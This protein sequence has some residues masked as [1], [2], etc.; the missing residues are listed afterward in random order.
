MKPTATESRWILPFDSP[1]LTLENA[2][3]KGL[4][5][6]RL[7]RLGLP[8]PPGFVVNAACYRSL[9]KGTALEDFI[10]DALSGLDETNRESVAQAAAAIR[11]RIMR[12]G[13][14][15]A[16][17]AE[18]KAAY[19][20]LGG[21]AAAVRSSATAEDLP[22]LSFA[23]QQ[24]T[25]LN[26]TGEENVI[27][28]VLSCLASLWTERAVAYRASHT[29][30]QTDVAIAVVV[31]TLVNAEWSGVMFTANPLSGSRRETVIE[32][33]PGLGESLVSGRTEPDRF[34]LESSTGRVLSQQAG[35]K[36]LVVVPRAAGGVEERRRERMSSSALADGRLSELCA[37]GQ[38]IAAA[39]GGPQDIEWAVR[40]EQIHILQARPVTSLFPVPETP[41]ASPLRAYFSFAGVQGVFDPLTPLGRNIF[42]MLFSAGAR[43]AGFK[44]TYR[45]QPTA[46]T[47]G[48]RLWI[49]ISPLL[50]STLGRRVLVVLRFIEPGVLEALR[51]LKD[52]PA[53][54]PPRPPTPRTFLRL[55]RFVIPIF[56]MMVTNWARAA[57]A[58]P[59]VAARIESLHRLVVS[60]ARRW[61]TLADCVRSLAALD[62]LIY[63][64]MPAVI[65]G[66]ATGM[67]P[68][69]ILLRLSR[70]LSGSEDLGLTVTRGASYNVTTAMDLCL[71]AAARR[72]R[73]N[74]E[75]VEFFK[76]RDAAA[77]AQAWRDGTLPVA[78]R[79]ALDDFFDRYGMRGF[80]EIDMGRPRWREDP[81]PVFASLA[82]MLSIEDPD[83]YPDAVQKRS[84]IEAES[85]AR[86]LFRLARRARGGIILVRLLRWTVRRVTLFVGFREAPKFSIIKCLDVY[87]SFLLAEG[88]RGVAA[89][90]LNKP[91]DLFYLNLWE[92]ERFTAGQP[93]SDWRALIHARRRIF[94]REQERRR[95]PRFL[96]S[97]GR[98]FY[99]GIPST[100][101]RTLTGSPVSPGAVEGPVR[102]VLSPHQAS[103]KSGEILVCVGTDPSWTPLF[104]SAGGLVT[105]VGGMMTHGAVVA[106]EYGIPAVVGVTDAV[107]RLHTG[108]HIRLD[109][110]T[111]VIT[112]LETE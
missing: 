40:D 41:P 33:V 89:G 80:S 9:V 5:L 38:R 46:A 36:E 104:L 2:G 45:T 1:R 26:V 54:P 107:T 67:G 68:L 110:S 111:G 28:S 4:N 39:W 69:F 29:I 24:D 79:R 90:T 48:E 100:G 27:H 57:R 25:Y 47:A 35:K 44:Y 75:S 59:E 10:L 42:Q 86:K 101:G 76:G 52:D 8:V 64:L 58:V 19:A 12:G 88:A 14:P 51:R 7:C 60:R 78:A 99:E 49:D 71:W 72:I 106:R 93:G 61:R 11:D 98:A 32:A 65:S 30:D 73:E 15:A 18:I 20:A 95:L 105:E 31:Q 77:C 22:E 91:D 74:G 13:L 62:G 50:R 17:A 81:L 84:R 92:L 55:F 53:F 103:L 66:V 16:A 102:V 70:H 82:G 85:A 63:R 56:R 96:L 87:R 34:I 112:L 97:D 43:R 94:D 108:Q 109:G 3:G 37:L 6:G 21:P 23:G 83:R